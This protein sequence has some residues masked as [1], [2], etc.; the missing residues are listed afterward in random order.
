MAGEEVAAAAPAAEGQANGQDQM[1]SL[2]Q[3]GSQ[4][5]G[6]LSEVMGAVSPELGQEMAALQSQYEALIEKAMSGG[7]PQSAGAGISSPQAA[8]AAGASP[9]PMARG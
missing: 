4:V 8:G 3:N 6:M 2:I 1:T 5:L 7:Q 9:A